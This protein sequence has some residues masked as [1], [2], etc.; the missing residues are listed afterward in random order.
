VT[1]HPSNRW[2]VALSPQGGARAVGEQAIEALSR[3]SSPEAV[4]VFDCKT[5]LKVFSSLLAN[6]E[7]SMVVDLLNHALIVQCLDFRATHLLVLSLCP[8]TLFTLKL[9]KNQRVATI[10][11]FYEDFRLAVYWKDVI[12][13]YDYFFAIQ[14]GPIVRA[15]ASNN[16]RYGFLPTAAN[17]D[18]LFDLPVI[19]RKSPVDVSFI[20]I[21]SLYRI[22]VLEFLAASG[23][24]LAIAGEGWKQYQ[25]PLDGSIINGAWTDV[26]Q[27]EKILSDATVGLNLSLSDPE[28]D[29]ENTQ[30]SPRVFDILRAGRVLVTED[31]P[32]IHET[33]KQCTFYTFSN[34][35][36]AFD[37]ITS[38][39]SQMENEIA[40]ALANRE[41]I[42]VQHMYENRVGEILALTGKE[43]TE[44]R[45]NS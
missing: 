24:K 13:G 26:S 5:Y 15:C 18:A 44:A 21:P 35:R 34:E 28:I 38:V 33:L 9:L 45:Y 4:K 37:V 16:V 39:I 8:V 19:G 29:R 7:E 23:L 22:R 25:G 42:R 27:W 43:N 12:A 2:F 6:P 10:H 17:S 41:I 36:Q 30:V 31:V 20:G 40:K 14:K 1:S 11:W 3:L 32:L